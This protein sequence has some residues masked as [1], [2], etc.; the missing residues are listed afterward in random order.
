MAELG[1]WTYLDDKALLYAAD[2]HNQ[3]HISK[4]GQFFK[5]AVR[6]DHPVS[7]YDIYKFRQN[8]EWGQK[9]PDDVSRRYA[10]LLAVCNSDLA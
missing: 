8:Q 10:N 9:R 6:L 7:D 1:G 5:W 4:G 3:M 2:Y